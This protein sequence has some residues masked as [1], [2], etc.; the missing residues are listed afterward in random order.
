MARARAA[1]G[2]MPSTVIGPI[3][4]LSSA[5]LCGNSSKLWNTMPMRWRTRRTSDLDSGNATPSSNTR[6]PSSF[7]SALVQ[8]KSV[9]LPEPDG[10]I[11]HITSPL[12]TCSDTSANATKSP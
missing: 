12:F 7:S 9:D 6:P 3:A 8:R 2:A 11:R 10:P 1:S 4:T 5:D